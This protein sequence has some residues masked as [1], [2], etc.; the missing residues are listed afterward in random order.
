[1]RSVAGLR[2]PADVLGHKTDGARPLVVLDC[3]HGPR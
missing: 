2:I 3:K 1:M